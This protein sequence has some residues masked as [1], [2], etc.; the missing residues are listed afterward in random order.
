MPG[1]EIWP[2]RYLTDDKVQP[3]SIESNIYLINGEIRTW[4]GKCEKVYTPIYR[5]KGTGEPERVTLGSY[6]MLNEKESL[7]AVDVATKAYDYGR[8]AWPSM[9]PRQRI[10]CMEKFTAGLKAIRNDVVSLVMWEICKTK[11]DAEKEVDRTISKFFEYEQHFIS[12][13]LI[14]FIFKIPLKH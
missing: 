8:G 7:A 5:S 3:P 10:T 2:E 6:G 14:Q 12:I 11:E 13:T 4:A 1:T 9:T